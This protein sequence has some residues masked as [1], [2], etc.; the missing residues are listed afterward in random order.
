M[1]LTRSTQYCQLIVG[2]AVRMEGKSRLPCLEK[3]LDFIRCA[4]IHLTLQ[5]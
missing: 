1:P 2:L 5:L 3:R 4:G